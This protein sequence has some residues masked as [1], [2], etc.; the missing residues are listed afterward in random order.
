MENNTGT[1]LEKQPL[2]EEMLTKMNAYWRA[3]NYLSA[4]QLYLLDNPLLKKPLSLDQI[5]KKIV[6]HWGT[7]PGQNFVYVHCN[8]VIK[9]YDLDM[10]LLSGP[11]HGGNFLIANTYLDG[12]YSEIYPNISQDEE[13]MQKMFKQ[14]SFPCGVPSHCAPETPGSINEGGEL[15][16]SIA[17]AFGAVFDN[18]DLIATVVVGDGEAETGP[19]ATSW[20][21][22]KFLNP[23]TDGAVLPIL[24]LNGYK[25]SNPTIFS[26][27]PHDEIEDF[28]K[29]CGWKPYFVEGDDPMT[30]HRKMAETMDTVIEEI[31]A[32]QKHARETGDAERPKWPMIVLRTPKGW[33]GPKVVD[34]QKIEGSFRAHQVPISMENPEEHLKLL[35][36]WL[37]SYHPEELFDEKGRLIP[38]LAELAPK[39]NARLGANPH[40]NGGLLLKDLRLPD[41]RTYGIPVEPGKT[42][43]QDMIELGG[44][45]RDIFRLNEDSKNFR[46]FGPDESM[47]NR[48]YRVFEAENRDWNGELKDDDDK[49]A[50]G[51]RI[52]DS[53]LSEHMCEG[54]LEGYLLTGRHGFFA[55]YE[56][57]IRI[58]DSMAAQHAKW[59]KVC[60]QLSW[61][62]PIASL[63]F[64]LSSNV[65]QQDH[66]GYTH[67]DPGFLDHI[68]NKKA[69]VVR[70]YLPPDTNC[71]LS[72]FDHCIRSKN[73]VNAIVASKHP[74]C[75]WLSMEQ[76]VKHCTQGIGIW[77][78]ASNDCGEEPDLVMACCGDTPTLE[79]MAA[80]TILRDELPE[81]KIRVVNVVDLFKLESNTKHPH[82][83]S[84]AEY[85]AIFTKDTPV[86]F[87]FHGYPTLIHEL[88]Y[89]RNNHN[90]S[91]H[92]YQE[93]GTIT[94]PFDMRVQNQLDRFDL[95]KDAIMHLP[96]LGN[97]G[98][99]LIQKMNDKLVEHKQY[100]AEYGQD[101][102]EIRNWQ[103][104]TPEDK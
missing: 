38:E 27:I 73:Y 19:L 71:L 94:T 45:I 43:A 48:L 5:K 29:G 92:G 2:C 54:W 41:F 101:L 32:I 98:S 96:Q 104:H 62:Q 50:R 24:H 12:S 52:M 102:E 1:C 69:D 30:M 63:N 26:R 100:I 22:N 80:V 91:V 7:V 17:H 25:I 49:L 46:I 9:R 23:V 15:G 68:A 35:N 42:K 65:W 8:R 66:N 56:A 99:F 36:D 31:K 13:G 83:L 60:N 79:T 18:P 58:V 51:G 40:A 57:F 39:G 82:G 95:V 6:G 21:S 84:D 64:I 97:R 67:Q 77:E 61:R 53:M 44:Y 20:Q 74:S 89:G 59:L 75:Q 3:A 4:G 10:I 11:G 103:W 72:C 85:D 33:T 37:R 87:A 16:Y 55:S 34:G 14:F 81:L 70:M 86:I 93:E 78:W 90:V 47:S 88:T 76:A 28:F